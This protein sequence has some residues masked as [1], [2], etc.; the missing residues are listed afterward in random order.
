[1]ESIKYFIYQISRKNHN[2][3]YLPKELRMIIWDK[4][5]PYPYLKCKI[6]NH[7]IITL[8]ITNILLNQQINYKI[9][10]GNG[11]CNNHT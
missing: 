8:E 2:L 7:V 6:C 4:Y 11:F 3:P 9:I 1:M 10:N 5:F